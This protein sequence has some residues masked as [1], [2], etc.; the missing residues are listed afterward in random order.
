M[1][2]KIVVWVVIGLAMGSTTWAQGREANPK[3]GTVA[4]PTV[5]AVFRQEARRAYDALD[6][7]VMAVLSMSLPS[8]A[9][10][11]LP[12][13]NLDAEKAVKEAKY[14]AKTKA[15]EAVVSMLGM[16]L[17]QTQLQASIGR[18]PLAEK[19][20]R[21]DEKDE[22][23]KRAIQCQLEVLLAIN[24]QGLEAKGVTQ[25]RLKTC[26]TPGN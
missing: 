9:L 7:L 2:L 24:P 26:L 10:D 1:K 12:T 13:L 23:Q 20:A 16:A 11:D 5:T 8:S 17:V 4:A 22:A 15:D 3:S 25:A 14:K 6:R 18:L 21:L 19:V